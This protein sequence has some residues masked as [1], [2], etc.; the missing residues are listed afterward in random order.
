MYI[1]IFKYLIIKKNTLSI[2]WMYTNQVNVIVLLSFVHCSYVTKLLV[3]FTLYHIK[4]SILG[5]FYF[6]VYKA[7]TPLFCSSCHNTRICPCGSRDETDVKKKWNK[8]SWPSDHCC[9]SYTGLYFKLYRLKPELYK[10]KTTGSL[11]T[12][13]LPPI[14]NCVSAV[15]PVYLS[16][17][18]LR[19]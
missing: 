19:K 10:W 15:F 1:Y 3:R 11:C 5:I 18:E 16:P 6:W 7:G 17:V 2:Y 4:V 13:D 12:A 14:E 8:K 9:Y